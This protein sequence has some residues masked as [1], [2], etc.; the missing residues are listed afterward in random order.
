MNTFLVIDLKC[1][2]KIMFTDVQLPVIVDNL[3]HK[4]TTMAEKNQ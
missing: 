2:F 4:I 1:Q 3:R